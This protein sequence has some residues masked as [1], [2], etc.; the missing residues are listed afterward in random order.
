MPDW[1]SWWCCYYYRGSPREREYRGKNI[2]LLPLIN[3]WG[4]IMPPR[5]K[6]RDLTVSKTVSL[7][8]SLISDI[9]DEAETMGKD[10]SATTTT[11]LRLGILYR[12]DQMALARA[13]DEAEAKATMR[14]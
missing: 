4:N 13:R 5:N 12:N 8:M 11:L 3:I 1:V 10:F 7:P 2:I 14:G 6:L 9:S